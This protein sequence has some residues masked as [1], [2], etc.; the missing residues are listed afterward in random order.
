MQDNKYKE[1]SK[2]PYLTKKK[3]K[4]EYEIFILVQFYEPIV[5]K[6]E[7]NVCIQYEFIQ[8]KSNSIKIFS[9]YLLV[10]LFWL[11]YVLVI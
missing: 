2:F 8:I 7:D 10:Q 4:I 6:H 5:R 1:A 11:I 3:K 9:F